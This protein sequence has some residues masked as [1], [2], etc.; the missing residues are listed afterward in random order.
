[1][2]N[3]VDTHE[4]RCNEVWMRL[5]DLN[6]DWHETNTGGSPKYLVISPLLFSSMRLYD[7]AIE[8]YYTRGVGWR[9]RSCIV[10]ITEQDNFME[11]I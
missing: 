6:R 11:L 8:T 2:D 3:L 5:I 1:M 7:Q 9:W 10:L 4:P